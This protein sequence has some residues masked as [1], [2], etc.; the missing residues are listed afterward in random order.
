MGAHA[1]D[2]AAAQQAGWG[3]EPPGLAR[4]VFDHVEELIGGGAFVAMTAI[5][6]VNVVSRYLF[7]DP[8]PGADELATL[9]FTWAVFVGAAAGVRQRLHIGIEFIVNWFPP[10]G[11]AALGLLVVLLL[12]DGAAHLGRDPGGGGADARTPPAH[13]GRASRPR[14]RRP[15]RGARL[16]RGAA[17]MMPLVF[18]AMA[19]L[20]ALGV[21]I[22]FTLGLASAIFYVL[23]P[24]VTP[25]FLVQ[26][27]V[28]S[29]ESFPLLAV[30]FFIFAG[31]VMTRGGISHRIIGLADALVGHRI[32]GLAQVN[33]LNSVFIGGM[34]G[35]GNA[36]AAIDAKTLVPVM[37]QK[38]Y[39]KPFAAA[40]TAASGVIAPIIP[41]GIGL[42][43]YGFIADVSVGRLFIG[44]IVPGLLLALG[45]MIAVHI[46]SKRRGYGRSRAQRASI[47][48]VLR[49]AREAA[50][51]LFLPILILGGLRGGAFTPT[52]AGAVA[53][54]Y[55]VFV[56]TLVFGELPVRELWPIVGESLAATAVVMLILGT[57]SALMWALTWE[58]LPVM[59]AQ[60]LLSVSNNPYVLLLLVNLLLLVLGCLME[61]TALLIIL[62]PI[63]APVFFK[64]G[65]DPVHFG[66]V[67][68]LNLTIG[69]VTPPVGTILY[70]VCAIVGL[71]I[72]E[73]TRELG[74][75]LLALII[76]LFV[77]TYVP[78]TVLWLPNLM[79]GK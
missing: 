29:T 8:I 30:P 66:L 46:V 31:A 1:Q 50:W 68:V 15:G 48:E 70:T 65:V 14:P 73:L 56:G 3:S 62:T 67:I 42:L 49:H 40:V 12:L 43:I 11:R 34:S 6:V 76:V 23:A 20:L 10:R 16:P 5:V 26:R 27:M 75:F 32:G 21:P 44:G 4:R 79:M 47:G 60:G 7:N 36:D 25:A 54:A 63:L 24:G 9:C 45:L 72:E 74:P 22:A 39:S 64:L 18:V 71:S 37:V 13:R 61:G 2:G 28:A 52:E 17:A 78:P 51:A 69:A 55:A 57:A 53:A 35:S 58:R 19:G 33:V 59:M 77:V 38:G 41:P